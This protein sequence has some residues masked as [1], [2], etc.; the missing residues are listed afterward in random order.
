MDSVLTY[1]SNVSA[2]DITRSI[3]YLNIIIKGIA[4]EVTAEKINN[5]WMKMGTIIVTPSF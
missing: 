4:G 5:R 1:K 3:D 2:K